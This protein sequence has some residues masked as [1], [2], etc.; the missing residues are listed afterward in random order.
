M[1]KL[2]N[3]IEKDGKKLVSARE[4]YDFLEIKKQ[5]TQWFEQQKDWFIENQDFNQLNLKVNLAQGGSINKIDYAITI[6]MAKEL[7]MMSRVEKGK[8]ARQYFIECETKLEKVKELAVQYKAPSEDELIIA[9]MKALHAKAE[10]LETQLVLSKS[11]IKEQAPKVQ[12]YD[13][14]LSSNSIFPTTIIAKE[15]GM[16]AIKLNLTLKSRGILIQVSN[17]WVLTAKYQS[18]GYTKTKT[19][20]YLDG[21]GNTQTSI[22]TVWTEK[23]RKFIHDSFKM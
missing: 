20:T 5:F 13:E 1:D 11:I 17:V 8:Q 18:F 10:R 14:V 6:D 21:N 12:Y 2:I 15:L 4:L 7:A 3:I 22:Q 16:S 19:Y 23:G 9:G